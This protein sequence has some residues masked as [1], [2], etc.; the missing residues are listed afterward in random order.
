VG[1]SYVETFFRHRVLLVLPLVGFLV[2]TAFAFIQPREYMA[3]SSVWIDT[4]VSAG[5]SVGSG[6]STPPSTVQSQLLTQYLATR[7][8][9]TAVAVNSPVSEKFKQAGPDEADEILAKLAKSVSVSTPGPQLMTVSVT[10]KN[11]SEATKTAEALLAQF[12]GFQMTDMQRQ[13]QSKADY[14]KSQLDNAAAAL[15]EAEHQLDQVRGSSSGRANDPA[16]AAAAAAVERAQKA[17]ADA[18]TAYATSSRALA[19]GDSTGLFVLDKPDRAWPQARRKTLIIGAAGGMTAGA[20]LSLLALL[21]LMARDKTLRDEQD[22]ARALSLDVVGAVPLARLEVPKVFTWAQAE[23][24]VPD[25][26]T[27]RHSPTF[28]SEPGKAGGHD[29]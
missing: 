26:E 13:E 19:T 6:G 15:K 1:R 29:E 14:D 11:A 23:D 8:F 9:L 4:P 16:A 18:A 17:Y 7:T 2:G 21:V 22:A 3:I 24:P 28:A 12:E 27:R 25:P 10:T 20:T 5:S